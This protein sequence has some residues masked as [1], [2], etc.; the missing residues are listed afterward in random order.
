[1]WNAFNREPISLRVA[2]PTGTPWTYNT[3]TIRESNGSA[4]NFLTTFCGLPEEHVRVEFSQALG[5]EHTGG[6]SMNG[7]MEI[8]IGVNSTTTISGTRG[9]KKYQDNTAEDVNEQNHRDTETA[10]HILAP[11]IGINNITANEAG[12]TATSCN[13]KFNGTASYYLMQG[14]WS[15]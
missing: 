12:T 15:G 3:A 7:V 8:G 9:V 4:V 10:R 13:L 2:D 11:G 14:T 5:I 6:G 1:M